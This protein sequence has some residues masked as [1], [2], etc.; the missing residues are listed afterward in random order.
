M[1]QKI[2]KVLDII[3]HSQNLN[4]EEKDLALLA[5]KDANKELEITAFKFKKTEQVKKTTANL[6]EETIEELEQKRKAVESQNRELEIETALERVRAIA[7]SMKEPADMLEVCHTISDQLEILNL[8]N[9]RNIQTAIIDE[10][11]GIY[12]NYEYFTQYKRTSILEIEIELHPTVVE[13]VKEI[14]KSNDAFFT[15]TIEGDAL[16]DWRKYRSSTNQDPDPILDEASEVHYYFYSIGPGALGISSY[17]SLNEEDI[18]IF[19][20]FRNVFALAYQRFIDIEQAEAQAREAQIETSLERIRATAMSM[21]K[22]DELLDVVEIISKELCILGIPEIR[23]TNINIFNDDIEKF[24]NYEYSEYVGKTVYEVYYNSHPSN[25]QFVKRMKKHAEDFMITEFTGNDLEEWKEWIKNQGQKLDSALIQADNLYYYDYSIGT[26][27]IGIS[28]FIPINKEHLEILNRIRNVFNL[29]Y[30][31]YAD[32]SLAE[33]QAR[34]AQI[35]TALERVRS[36]AMAMH[37]SEDLAETVDTFF[38]ELANL[39]VTTHRCGVGI[40]DAETQTTDIRATTTTHS[41]EIKKVAGKLKLSGHPVLDSIFEHWKIQK[42]Y[43]PVLRGNEIKDYYKVMNPQIAFPDFADDEIQ[44]GYYFYFEEGGVFAWT[45]NELVESDLQIFR[46]YTSV[47][48]LTYRRYIDLKEAEAQAREAKIEAALER[49][50]SRT[51]AMHRSNELAETASVLFEQFSFLGIIPKRCSIGIIN[52]ADN[53]ADFWMTSNE[54]EVIR[55]ANTVPMNEHQNLIDLYSTWKSK[56]KHYYFTLKGKGRADWT[57]YLMNKV[58]I[59]IPEYQPETLNQGELLSEP[60]IFN[61]FFFA[62]GFIMLHTIED[63]A[64]DELPTLQRFATVFEQ[65]YTRFIDLQKAEEQAREA[66]I[67][68]ALERVRA[69]AMAMHKSEDLTSSVATVFSELYKLGLKTVR[70]GIGIFNDTSR[71]VNVWTTSPDNET[72]K[73]HLSG[74]E[75]LKGHPF[76]EKIYEAWQKQH[77]LS[78]TLK[79]KELTDYYKYTGKSNLPVAAPELISNDTIQYYHCIMFPAGGLFAFRDKKFSEEAMI[80]MKR[81]TEVFHLA[82][83]RHLDL[84]QAEEQNK[85]IQS[86]NE[87]KT[88]ELEEARQ[89]Q[90]AMLPKEIPQLQNLDIAV[91][92]QTA[93]EVGGDY[94]DFSTKDDGSLNIC[95]GDATGHG[96]KAGIMVSSMKS[97]FTTNSSKMDIESFFATANS[98][99]K[100]MGLKRMMM[101]LILLNINKN[102]FK[103][104]NAGM[105][106]V[107]W[108]SK[109]IKKVNEITEHGMPIGAMNK[110][111][112]NVSDGSL[113]K[114]DTLL[115]MS[116]GMPELQNNRKEM[117][118]YERIRNRFKDIAEKAPEEIVSYLKN[119]SAGWVNNSDPDDDVT[120]VVIKLKS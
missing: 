105:P 30:Q 35:E 62:Q 43:H 50:R 100:S 27:S 114:G 66:Q 79:G 47:L 34:E 64:Q 91:Y 96:M 85:I 95:L 32:I 38:S 56:K 81:F 69:K 119:E 55:G 92:M 89:L 108:F 115:L 41:N 49:V 26:G 52:S 83:T 37:N 4:T 16:E 1:N 33:A 39:N 80:L 110:S 86:E 75:I 111:I 107:F 20:R 48:S 18:N 19:K 117:Y 54:G 67:E 28:T 102:A 24:L 106:P 51:M 63:L 73:T 60:A 9:I 109:K 99:V 57:D 17:S 25:L 101:G 15:K 40:V 72:E 31:R 90:L 87:R 46:R 65:T 118:G 116:D 120:F 7:L 61:C 84:K 12:L 22:A 74:V 11:K 45:D 97:I 82:F 104:V 6:L 14:K 58:K 13:F 42:E 36:K 77:D 59:Y 98:G 68:A 10:S 44:Y 71:K 3:Q 53:T 88:Q 76:L 70:C 5:L 21:R 93:T 2:Q 113:E 94:Y 112:Y 103:L 78:Y 29:A 23:N 8:K